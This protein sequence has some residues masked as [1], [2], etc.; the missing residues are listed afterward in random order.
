MDDMTGDAWSTGIV[1]VVE[2][3]TQLTELD[4]GTYGWV[5]VKI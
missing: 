2:A 4:V 3:G 1:D 5:F